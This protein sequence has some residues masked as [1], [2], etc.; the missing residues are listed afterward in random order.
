MKKPSK[1]YLK[2]KADALFSQIIRSKGHCEWCGQDYG[3]MQTHHI[4]GRKNMR[5]R[6]DLMNGICLDPGC[7]KFNIKSAHEDSQ[8]F[9]EWLQLHDLE[10]YH[11]L[12]KAKHETVTTTVEWYQ[13]NIK[14]LT[15]ILEEL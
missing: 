2:K 5:L 13:D 1:T 10:R 6:Y 7:H 14:R 3:Q 8:G 15:Q 4:I 11:Y 12:D 9:M